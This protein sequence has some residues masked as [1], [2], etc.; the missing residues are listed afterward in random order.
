M[1]TQFI[2]DEGQVQANDVMHQAADAMLT[3]LARTEAALRPL[4]DAT[5]TG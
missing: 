2:D 4:R 1:H 3:E 5:R